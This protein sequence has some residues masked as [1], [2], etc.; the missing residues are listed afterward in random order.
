MKEVGKWGIGSGAMGLGDLDGAVAASPADVMMSFGR[1]APPDQLNLF[2]GLLLCCL[3]SLLYL[4][5]L[6]KT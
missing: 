3:S 5:I 2:V 6:F 4:Q 1:S